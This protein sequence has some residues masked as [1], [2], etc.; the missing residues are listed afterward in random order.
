M[1]HIVLTVTN[2]LSFDQRM[3]R[4]CQ[5]LSDVG[6]Q[7]TLVGRI[8]KKCLPLSPKD[9]SQKRLSM[10]FHKGKFFYLEYHIRLFFF[11]L[12]YRFD[13]ACSI[14]ADTILPVLF[15]A[16]LKNKRKIF[17]AHELYSEVPELSRRKTEKKIWAFIEQKGIP[18]FNKCYTVSHSVA[19]HYKKETGKNFEVIRNLP[20]LEEEIPR[21]SLEKK[22]IILY[23]GA[24]NVGR[25]LEALIEAAQDLPVEV[26]LAGEGD[27]SGELRSLVQRLNLEEKILFL[28]KVP[29]QELKK[30]TP[31]AWL[32]YNLLEPR[33]LSYQYSLA[34]KFFDYI[35]ALV[36][37]LSPDFPEYQKINV[38]HEVG[39]LS[40]LSKEEII[41]NVDFLI[42]NNEY[43]SRLVENCIQARREFNWQQEEK[44]L[45]NIYQNFD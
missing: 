34:N 27:L 25:G 3:Q 5:S 30:I 41:K 31:K 13:I 45:I 19:E 12:F 43:Y 16:G 40:N 7:V 14:D 24:L 1:T 42:K 21:P 39:I 35:H 15:A 37:G 2:D 38:K 10:F 29:P 23:Q 11:L 32:G 26:W 6:F 18:K 36:P 44:K 20:F 28:G 4:I 33:G 8:G 22:K 9:Y 17:D